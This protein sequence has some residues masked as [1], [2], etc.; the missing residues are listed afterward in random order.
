MKSCF[1]SYP[2][3]SLITFFIDEITSPLDKTASK[4]KTNPLVI[5]YFNTLS[6]PALV[7]TTPPI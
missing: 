1:T 6:P 3:L 2:E 5:P 7:D 4:P